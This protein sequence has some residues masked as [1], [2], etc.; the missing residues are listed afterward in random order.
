MIEEQIKLGLY[1]KIHHIDAVDTDFQYI[2]S[3]W[4]VDNNILE[5]NIDAYHNA[6]D[7]TNKYSQ[8]VEFKIKVKSIEQINRIVSKFEDFMKEL[9][10]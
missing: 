7:R 2:N 8:S 10:R 6:Y 4:Y 1:N 3:C 9:D 5:I